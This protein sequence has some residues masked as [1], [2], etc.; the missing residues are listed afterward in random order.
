MSGVKGRLVGIDE[1]RQIAGEPNPRKHAGDRVGWLYLA[2]TIVVLAALGFWKWRGSGFDWRLFAGQFG[3]ASPAWIALGLA[4][5]MMSYAGRAYRWGVMLGAQRPDLRFADLFSATAIGFTAT[6][7]FGRPGELVR[8]YLI[9]SREGLPIASQVAVWFLERLLD[10][11][12][13]I[14]LFG[15]ALSNL[16]SG[17]AKASPRVAGLL[18]AGGWALLASGIVF[19]VPM[20]LFWLF[21]AQCEQRLSDSVGFLPEELARRVRSFVRSFLDGMGFARTEHGGLW[22][23]FLSALEWIVIVSC[24]YAVFRAFPTTSGF[25]F[26]DVVIT[27]GVI[28]IGNAVQ[29]PGIGGGMQFATVFAL[30][31]LYGLPLEGSTS[32]AMALWAVNF[33][34][35]VPFGLAFAF[36][37][38]LNWHKLRE[39]PAKP[40]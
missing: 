33:L 18:Q 9:A 39:L 32:V 6:V 29:I 15:F 17:A 26:I 38:G 8:P 11:V 16:G 25:S 13:V 27:L 31:E 28:T 1:S 40:I 24:G 7:F 10:L 14:L 23:L 19:A 20:A 37:E 36:R 34:I 35:I 5:A 30:T 12:M 2:L 21:P 4:L 3:A 22:L